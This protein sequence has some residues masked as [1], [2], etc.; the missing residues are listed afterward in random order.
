MFGYLTTAASKIFATAPHVYSSQ[1][2]LFSTTLSLFDKGYPVSAEPS[3]DASSAGYLEDMYNSWLKD[4]GSV[5]SVRLHN[6][7]G[8][9]FSFA[10]LV[11]SLGMLIFVT[12]SLRSQVT[13]DRQ[14]FH[15]KIL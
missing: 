7:T 3:L 5:H 2:S 6:K 1:T 15:P 13:P 9:L 11:F 10:P 12:Q 8:L 14:T 4:P